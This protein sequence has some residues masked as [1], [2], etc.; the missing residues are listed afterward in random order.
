MISDIVTGLIET[1][2]T[3][4]PYKLCHEL[5]IKI[6]YINLGNNIGGFLQRTKEGYEIIHINSFLPEPYQ[7]YVLAHE[8][9]HAV[10]HPELSISY[11]HTSMTYIRNKYELEADRFAVKLLLLTKDI[12]LLE[13]QNMT[14]EQVAATL[15]LPSALL[16]RLNFFIYL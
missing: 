11:F 5:G 7:T 12:D 13:L 3:S 8:L 6:N 1:Y 14:I 4:N 9:G 2:E 15:E 10:C 16:E